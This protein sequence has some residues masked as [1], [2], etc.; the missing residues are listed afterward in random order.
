M[1]SKRKRS[2]MCYLK[3]HACVLNSGQLKVTKICIK[4]YSNRSLHWHVW[5]TFVKNECHFTWRL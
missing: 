2:E 1:Q 5:T 4:H 3:G